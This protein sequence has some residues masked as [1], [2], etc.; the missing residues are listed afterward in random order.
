MGERIGQDTVIRCLRVCVEYGVEHTDLAANAR[1][2]AFSAAQEPDEQSS[3][4]Y[5]PSDFLRQFAA[6]IAVCLGLALLAHVLLT[7]TGEC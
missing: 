7:V 4:Q 2:S 3:T 6:V 5:S 1:Q